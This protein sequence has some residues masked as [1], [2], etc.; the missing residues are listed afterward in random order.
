MFSVSASLLIAKQPPPP[1]PPVQVEELWVSHPTQDNM[2]EVGKEF[3]PRASFKIVFFSDK[4]Y[5]AV[6]T[7]N[8]I[9]VVPNVGPKRVQ[10]YSDTRQ[11]IPENSLAGVAFKACPALVKD[12]VYEVRSEWGI[13]GEAGVPILRP[14]VINPGIFIN[15]FVP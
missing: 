13:V 6:L 3:N 7:I 4:V 9:V 5:T 15:T 11:F 2:P 1:P 10:I 8:Q 14:W 12:A